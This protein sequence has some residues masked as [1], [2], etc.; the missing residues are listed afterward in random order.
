MSSPLESDSGV[1]FHAPPARAGAPSQ[2]ER[3]SVTTTTAGPTNGCVPAGEGSNGPEARGPG[4]V[5]NSSLRT[6]ARCAREYL[7]HNEQ[8]YEPN[9][10]RAAA[11]RFGTMVHAGLEAWWLAPP[12]EGR[13]AAAFAAIQPE[14]GVEADPFDLVRVEELLRGYDA[15]WGAEQIETLAVE[16]EFVTDL[17]NPETGAASRTFRLGGKLDGIARLDDGRV[18]IVEHKT[19][20]EQIGAGSTY[21]QR[22]VIDP[23]VSTYFVGARALGFDVAACLYDVIGKPGIRP[24]KA[25][26]VESR[27]FTKDGRLYAAQREADETPE[28]F[29][30]RYRAA[31]EADPS[32]VYQRGEVVRLE[33]EERDAAFDA[34]QRAAQIRDARRTGCWPRNP[35]ACVRYGRTCDFW[36]VCTRTGLIDD[37]ALFRRADRAHR[38]LSLSTTNPVNG[39]TP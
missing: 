24:A 16:A 27:K 6:F 1:S 19:T 17:R 32:Q 4:L 20:S 15:R 21:W 39:A 13:L 12:G 10:E 8:G 18:V 25:T 34:W 36:A 14:P 31:I 29:R 30:V 5:T 35:D 38:E 7:H 26:P 23:Q 33:D 2:A 9:G 28:D 3:P 37:P 22:L 11:L